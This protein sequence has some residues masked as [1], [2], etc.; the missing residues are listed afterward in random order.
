MTITERIRALRALLV[1]TCELSELPAFES[2]VLQLVTARLRDI[3]VEL[4]KPSTPAAAVG[5]GE[6]AKLARLAAHA[7]VSINTSPTCGLVTVRV[8]GTTHTGPDLREAI[9]T[10]Y[11]YHLQP[12]NPGAIE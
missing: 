2:A 1:T 9:A 7:T 10:A 5:A 12:R 11:S 3:A 6:L 4:E 8:G